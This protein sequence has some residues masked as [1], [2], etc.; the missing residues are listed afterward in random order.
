MEVEL[1]QH[2]FHAVDD[3]VAASIVNNLNGMTVIQDLATAGFIAEFQR[4][5]ICFYETAQVNRSLVFTCT[6]SK[7]WCQFSQLFGPLS[8]L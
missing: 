1:F 3:H 7:F 4:F 6:G 2:V 5:Q 8:P